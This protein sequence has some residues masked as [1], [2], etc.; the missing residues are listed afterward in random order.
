[1]AMKRSMEPYVYTYSCTGQRPGSKPLLGTHSQIHSL[2]HGI[3]SWHK[4]TAY[5]CDPQHAE[6][7]AAGLGITDAT[8]GTVIT[9]TPIGTPAF[10]SAHAQVAADQVCATIEKMMS[11]PLKAQ[12]RFLLLTISCQCPMLHYARAVPWV[13]ISDHTCRTEASV[14]AAVNEIMGVPRDDPQAAAQAVLRRALV[15]WESCPRRRRSPKGRSL[16][17]LR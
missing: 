14:L 17:Q 3:W 1:M 5:S 8:E 12:D 6:A 10:E 16:P 9:G 11:L 2:S 15:A 13:H 4:C 7:V